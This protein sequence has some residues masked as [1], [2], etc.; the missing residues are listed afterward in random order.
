MGSTFE[1]IQHFQGFTFDV[2]YGSKSDSNEREDLGLELVYGIGFWFKRR[3][4]GKV[5]DCC[6][7]KMT[8]FDLDTEVLRP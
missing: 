3:V 1:N 5:L 4:G 7:S 8:I 6:F 2:P